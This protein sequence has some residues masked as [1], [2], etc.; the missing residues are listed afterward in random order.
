[1]TLKEGGNPIN[2]EDWSKP[3]KILKK[4]GSELCEAGKTISLDMT[5]FQWEGD[6]YVIWS[7]RQFLPKDLGAWLYIAKMQICNFYDTLGRRGNLRP[8]AWI[9]FGELF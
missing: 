8:R 4:D 5:C 3:Q 2:K 6:Y 1:M 7:Q 9:F